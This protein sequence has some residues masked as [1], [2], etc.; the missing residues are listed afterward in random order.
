MA[1]GCWS[2]HQTRCPKRFTASCMKT[3][4]I[5]RRP[6]KAQCCPAWQQDAN[7]L[8]SSNKER[9]WE[10]SCGHVIHKATSL[11][12]W[13]MSTHA[14]CGSFYFWCSAA[15]RG[16]SCFNGGN[17]E[18]AGVEVLSLSSRLSVGHHFS[19]SDFKVGNDFFPPFSIS[20]FFL[21]VLNLRILLPFCFAY[22]ARHQIRCW[23]ETT[24][25]MAPAFLIPRVIFELA[26]CNQQTFLQS[27][28][29]IKWLMK[30]TFADR[31]FFSFPKTATVLDS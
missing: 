8:D 30:T 16:V 1:R 28:F 31:L 5:V 25:K 13:R 2:L 26:Q 9:L 14:H 24:N 17:W 18:F 15:A 27:N 10:Y 19:R 21:Q 6:K 11:E 12:P 29:F 20:L 7:A 4:L 23:Q 3:K 22:H